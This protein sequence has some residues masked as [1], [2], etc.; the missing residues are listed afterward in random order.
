VQVFV[1]L[2]DTGEALGP[3]VLLPR[4]HRAEAHAAFDDPRARRAFLRGAAFTVA[5]LAAGEALVYDSRALHCGGAN[6]GAEERVVFYLSLAARGTTGGDC[7]NGD[8]HNVRSIRQEL[9]GAHTLAS[10]RAAVLPV[11]DAR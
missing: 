5:D 3:T 2:Q 9:R 6:E 4:S 7:S 1:A 10:L 11:L 8:V